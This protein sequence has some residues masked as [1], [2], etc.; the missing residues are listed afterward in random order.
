VCYYGSGSVCRPGTGSTTVVEIFL[1]NKKT[2]SETK[3]LTI[4]M[5]GKRGEEDKDLLRIT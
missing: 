3:L 5:P 4:L 2:L 1:L